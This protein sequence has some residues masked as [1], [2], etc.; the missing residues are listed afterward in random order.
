M[1]RVGAIAI[2]ASVVIGF[3]VIQKMS[4][5]TLEVKNRTLKKELATCKS[6]VEGRDFEAKWSEEFSEALTKELDV[7]LSIGDSNE[8]SN[9]SFIIDRF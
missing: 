9:S 2:F 5:D 8:E 4:I 1:Y 7:N 3:I 6:A